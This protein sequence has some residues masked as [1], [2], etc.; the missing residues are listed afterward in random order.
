MLELLRH[1]NRGLRETIVRE[2]QRGQRGKALKDYLFDRVD[3]NSA[4][5]FSPQKVAQARQKRAEIEAQKEEEVLQKRKER[6]LRQK[7]AE[8]KRQ[9][10]LERKRQREEKT[11][12]KRREKETRQP[13]KRADWRFE[14][15]VR[16]ENTTN[17]QL[18][19][20]ACPMGLDAL[21]AEES[22]RDE[23]IVALPTITQPLVVPDPTKGGSNAIN[24]VAQRPSRPK[25]KPKRPFLMVESDREV[26]AAYGDLRRSQRDRKRPRWLDD[27]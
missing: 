14:T 21:E 23:I 9:Q 15:W 8:E 22:T 18:E 4:Q 16:Q 19:H 5:V 11:E 24:T 6:I 25:T 1:E 12:R 3:P 7:R 17:G 13:E 20:Q 2:K 27:S 26:V 10:A